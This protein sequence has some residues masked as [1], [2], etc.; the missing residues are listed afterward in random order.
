MPLKPNAW[1]GPRFATQAEHDA[2][3]RLAIRET[4]AILAGRGLDP[5]ATVGPGEATNLDIY[6][7][8]G[9]ARADAHHAAWVALA[10]NNRG[11][12]TLSVS[13]TMAEELTAEDTRRHL[14][15]I[16]ALIHPLAETTLTVFGGPTMD[17]SFVSITIYPSGIGGTDY[18]FIRATTFADALAQARTWATTHGAVLRNTLIR[19]M[20]LAVIEITDE[21]GH[22]TEGLL[23][24]KTFTAT[25]IA[26]THVA[27]CQRASEMAGNA[28]YRVVLARDAVA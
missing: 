27:A 5:N 1:I 6:L 22:C 7:A 16:A 21:H 17:K 11:V 13:D 2:Y 19:R 3:M 9:M 4:R 10:Q 20:A 24:A 12:I 28:P 23:R 25:Q 14:R 26:D 8:E 15:Q 18:H